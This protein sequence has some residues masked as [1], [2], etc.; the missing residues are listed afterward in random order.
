MKKLILLFLGMLITGFVFADNA[1]VASVKGKVEVNRNNTWIQVKPGDKIAESEMISTGFNSEAKIKYNDSVLYLAALTRVTLDT[2][3]S[4]STTDKVNVYLNTGAVRSKVNH[5]ENKRVSYTVR[6]PVAVA[7]VRGTD[8]V[9]TDNSSIECFDGAVAVCPTFM[10][11]TAA[12]LSTNIDDL[13]S[14]DINVNSATANTPSSDISNAVPENSLVVGQNQSV[15][16]NTAGEVANV[17]ANDIYT[18][19]NNI[20]LGVSSA[21]IADAIA[22]SPSTLS[23]PVFIDSKSAIAS[24]TTETVVTTSS[25][26]IAISISE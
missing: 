25:V 7:S 2:L 17:P 19:L 14:M 24:T 15:T 4:T 10:V 12:L 8:F 18:N 3:I 23:N 13:A 6:N 11:D 22:S 1:I 26:V 20:V 5:T 16:F 21:S 9:M